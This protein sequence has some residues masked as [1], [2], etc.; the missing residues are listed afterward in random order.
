VTTLL[1]SD[2][3]HTGQSLRFFDGIAGSLRRRRGE[4]AEQPHT[5]SQ[6]PSD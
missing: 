4:C 6:D 5:A 3:G 1:L 2:L